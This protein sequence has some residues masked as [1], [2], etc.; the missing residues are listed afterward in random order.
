[1]HSQ[2]LSQKSG[3]SGASPSREEVDPMELTVHPLAKRLP[4]WEKND[5]RFIALVEDIRERGIQAP[6][7]VDAENRILDGVE[8]W[9]A[10]KQLQLKEVPIART[11]DDPA[12]VIVIGLALRKHYSKGALAYVCYPLLKPAHEA[13]QRRRIDVLKKGSA[14]SSIQSTTGKIE[15]FCE[16]LGFGRDL[17]FQA[18]AAQEVFEKSDKAVAEWQAKHPEA[19]KGMA[20]GTSI[21]LRA[22]WE[23]K[24]LNGEI[25]LGPMLA[26]IAGQDAT[27]GKQREDSGQLSLFTDWL[28]ETEVRFQ[29]WQRLQESEKRHVGLKIRE[30][31]KAM[32]EDLR[33]AWKKALS[34]AGC[35]NDQ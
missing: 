29:K 32:P 7:R 13:A 3:S 31:V 14:P 10:A 34:A 8:T 22:H 21:D 25:G 6:L 33:E 15:D 18:K 11:S 5:Q 19:P 27:K 28:H 26:G 12:T 30:L 2:T 35:A 1:M 9:K 23:P 4:R 17:F 16:F 24:L 20:L